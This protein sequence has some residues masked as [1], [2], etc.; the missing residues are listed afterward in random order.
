MDS[1]EV[2][3]EQG[4]PENIEHTVVSDDSRIKLGGIQLW[5]RRIR[6]TGWTGMV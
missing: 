5:K 1:L 2:R 3:N 4:K 6:T